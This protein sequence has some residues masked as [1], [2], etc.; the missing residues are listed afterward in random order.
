MHVGLN[1]VYLVPGETGGME[2]VARELIPELAEIPGLRLTA[3]VNREAE[4]AG[5]GPW[6]ELIPSVT[7][8]VHARNRFAWVW[9][10]QRHLPRL[11]AAAGC[12]VVHSLAST[13]PVRGPFRRVTTIHDLNYKLVPE[14]HFG[15]LGLGMRVLVPAAA[16]RSHRV[17]VDAAS[18]RADLIRHLGVAADKIDVAPLGVAVQPDAPATPAAELRAKLDLDE[19][20]LVLSLSAKRPHKNLPRLLRALAAMDAAERPSLV[21]PGYPTPH[22]AELRQLAGVARHRRPGAHCPHWLPA[23]DSRASTHSRPLSSSRRSTRGSACPC[24]R[25]WP[26]ACRWRARIGRRFPRSRATPRCCSIPRTCMAIR[27]AI[28][29]LLRDASWPTASARRAARGRPTFTWRRTAELTAA[30]YE[31]ALARRLACAPMLGGRPPAMVA[32]EILRGRNY[33]ALW[34]MRRVYPDFLE[35]AGRYFLGR[36]DYPYACRLRTPQGVVAPTLFSRHDMWTVNE[37]FCRHDYGDDRGA[38]RG[39]RHRL[40]HRH[41]RDV[42]PDPEPRLPGLAL[43][44]RPAQCR[45][46]ARRTSRASRTGTRCARRRLLLPPGRSRS[47]SRTAGAMAG[48]G[49]DTGVTIEVSGAGI[50]EIL[51]EVLEAVAGDRRAEDRHR[52]VRA[53]PTRRARAGAASPRADRLPRGRAPTRAP[54]GAVRLRVPQRDLGAPQPQHDPSRVV[55]L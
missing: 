26:A 48:V 47:A 19:R 40:E 2:V 44:A 53:R 20:P 49:V 11:A 27:A 6:G 45:A 12:D 28:E 35:N 22:E 17:I 52:G 37:V 42:L 33:Q 8:P 16:R 32:R 15:L 51:G 39:R 29:R 3:F 34:R 24:S 55:G 50:N 38:Q 18:T 9:G 43:R 46:S 4:Q 25:R 7:V 1:L 54:A 21:V 13:A 5:G 23:A 41:Q 31:R 30:S 14:S 10:E 36:G